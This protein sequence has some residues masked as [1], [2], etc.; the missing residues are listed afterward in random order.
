M[1]INLKFN[2]NKAKERFK[3]LAD[4]KRCTTLPWK[5]H[6]YIVRGIARGLLYLHQD[7]KLHIIHR[8]LK[9]SNILIDNNLSPKILDFG[10]AMIFRD[11]E[12]EARIKRVIGTW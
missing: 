8:D 5:M 1:K 12:K 11:N 7:S 9:A 2:V 6:F 3:F 10:L 4:G